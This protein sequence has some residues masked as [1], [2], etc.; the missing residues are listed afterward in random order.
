[1]NWY[2]CEF[3][4]ENKQVSKEKFKPVCDICGHFLSKDIL[5]QR[6]IES[7]R[8]KR[9]LYCPDC[10]QMVYTIPTGVLRSE[11]IEKNEFGKI[12][13]SLFSSMCIFFLASIV[14]L[15]VFIFLFNSTTLIILLV[16]SGLFSII[17]SILIIGNKRFRRKINDYD[18]D[19]MHSGYSFFCS[20]CLNGVG[21]EISIIGLYPEV[22]S[23]IMKVVRDSDSRIQAGRETKTREIHYLSS[24]LLITD[25][26]NV[27]GII[28]MKEPPSV[29]FKNVFNSLVYDL[30]EHYGNAINE[31]FG[32][33]EALKGINELVQSSLDLN[34]EKIVLILPK[35]S[36]PKE[37]EKIIVI[38]KNKIFRYLEY[39]RLNHF[40]YIIKEK[41]LFSLEEILKKIKL[42]KEFKPLTIKLGILYTPYQLQ[43]G[44]IH[45]KWVL[46]LSQEKTLIDLYIYKGEDLS[47]EGFL[48][49][50]I[51]SEWVISILP[52][53]IKHHRRNILKVIGVLV[54]QAVKMKG[55]ENLTV[56][57]KELE[58]SVKKAVE[59]I[60]Y[61]M[62]ENLL[63]ELTIE[64]SYFPK[65][66]SADL[67]ELSEDGLP[68]I[69]PL[70]LTILRVKGIFTSF[71]GNVIKFFNEQKFFKKLFKEFYKKG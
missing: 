65:I 53:R 33:L 51:I 50:N 7:R 23:E 54:N 8:S 21:S 45:E 63:N 17:L 64:R 58:E 13:Y 24:I 19:L 6:E 3:C 40:G 38:M 11:F 48:N 59:K 66:L 29:D 10:N 4:N 71:Y 52:T 49:P 18:M 39:E 46:R 35:T 68:T 31:L 14:S 20:I 2:Y 37:Y 56:Q 60:E 62:E 28:K 70:L 30:N 69:K 26:G 12:E 9:T 55:Q 34:K 25:Y 57:L 47:E 15:I 41:Q 1:M 16:F 42:E 32:K 61:L 67:L 44:L 43:L 22:I 36:H 5:S 27:R